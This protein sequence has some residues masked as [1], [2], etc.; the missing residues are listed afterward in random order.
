MVGYST[1]KER[2]KDEILRS[3]KRSLPTGMFDFKAKRAKRKE[4]G[5]S[6]HHEYHESLRAWHQNVVLESE[7]WLVE[8]PRY[9]KSRR[10]EE[11]YREGLR[12]KREVWFNGGE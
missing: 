3:V 12:I 10:E 9:Y 8:N 5:A 11:K 4:K 1:E 2:K 6:E 7:R